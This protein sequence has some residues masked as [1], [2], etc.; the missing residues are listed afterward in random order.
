MH[1]F[2][3]KVPE[4]LSKWDPKSIWKHENRSLD[5]EVAQDRPRVVQD[6][7][8]EAQGLPNDKVLHQKMQYLFPTRKESEV[9]KQWAMV[10]NRQQRAIYRLNEMLQTWD[11]NIVSRQRRFSAYMFLRHCHKVTLIT[12]RAIQLGFAGTNAKGSRNR[13]CGTR[14]LWQ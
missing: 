2:W 1:L 13:P 4:N 9:L 5:P 3:F 14:R 8:V 7:K 6:A 11:E 12:Q 10:R